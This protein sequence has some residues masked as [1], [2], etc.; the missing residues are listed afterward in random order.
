MSRSQ[1]SERRELFVVCA[2]G[3]E[4]IVEGELR[5]L[6]GGAAE[7]RAQGGGIEV[8]AS[9][10][11]LLRLSLELRTATRILARLA[12][13]RAASFAEL[14][15]RAGRLAWEGL[16]RPGQPLVVRASAERSRLY[17]T[18]GIAERIA[19]GIGERL[20]APAPLCREEDA[21]PEAARVI[22]RIV[23]D[24]CTLS[25]D[26][27]GEALHRRGYRLATAKAPL[28][29]G[30]AAALLL[31]SVDPSS[32]GEGEGEAEAIVDPMCGSGTLA[33][34]AA[35][36]A[37]RTPPGLARAFACEGWPSIDRALVDA[38][39]AELAA[40]P[41]VAPPAPIVASD[42]DP[43][44][45]AATEANA[46]R[47]GVR[48]WLTIRQAELREATPPGERGLVIT[49]PPYGVRIAERRRLPAIYA[50]LG[51]RLRE[52]FA[53]PGLRWR[54]AL[55]V[56]DPSLAAATGLTLA[57]RLHF[58]NGGIPVTLFVGAIT[59]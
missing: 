35:L 39:R 11:D 41:R 43:G 44:A 33:I 2:P 42:R 55:L 9:D 32:E 57:P 22:A 26:A 25:V 30:L 27:S 16:L 17:H 56:P 46:E 10:R 49:N 20:G 34:E 40:R 47:A 14:H 38:V 18:G 52:R 29:E 51:A 7:L 1:A 5:G 58:R 21:P 23:R 28:R 37:S 48:P 45:I 24:Q 53:G 12:S 4:A 31:A 3:L 8:E 36:L 15:R 19:R 59:R 50:A 13:F 54:L 6:L